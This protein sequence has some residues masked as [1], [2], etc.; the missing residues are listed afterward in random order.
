MLFIGVVV[1][2]ISSRNAA[3]VALQQRAGQAAGL[4]VRVVHPEKD[5]GTI[6]LQL[7]GQTMPYTADRPTKLW[8]KPKF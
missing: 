8:D 5:S 2:G 6:N 7:P 4:V 1:S 3:T